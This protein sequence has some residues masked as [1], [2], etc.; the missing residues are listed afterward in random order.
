MIVVSIT[1]I[2][3]FGSLQEVTVNDFFCETK[4]DRPAVTITF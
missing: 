1:L 3:F 4:L 2:D